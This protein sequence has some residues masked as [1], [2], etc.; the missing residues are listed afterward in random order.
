MDLLVNISASKASTG[1][2]FALQA[3]PT[4]LFKKFKQKCRGFAPKE[5]KSPGFALQWQALHF[6]ISKL[7]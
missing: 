3:N 1:G 2:S 6:H 4:K 5:R 7:M